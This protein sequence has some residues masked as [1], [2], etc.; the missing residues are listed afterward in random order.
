MYFRNVV[1]TV[2]LATL[3]SAAVAKQISTPY[4]TNE[5]YED[6]VDDEIFERDA[7]AKAARTAAWEQAHGGA[8]PSYHYGAE[9]DPAAWHVAR[10]AEAEPGWKIAHDGQPPAWLAHLKSKATQATDAVKNAIPTAKPFTKQGGGLKKHHGSHKLHGSHARDIEDEEDDQFENDPDDLFA[11]DLDDPIPDFGDQEV[12]TSLEGLLE[13]RDVSVEDEDEEE[14]EEEE[15]EPVNP[16][17]AGYDLDVLQRRSDGTADEIDYSLE[18][19]DIDEPTDEE[20]TPIVQARDLS[21]HE[22]EDYDNYLL[23]DEHRSLLEQIGVTKRDAE[24]DA[25]DEAEFDQELYARQEANGFFDEDEDHEGLEARAEIAD[26]VIEYDVD[27]NA[28]TD[29]LEA[30]DIDQKEIDIPADLD[31]S[32]EGLEDGPIFA[33]GVDEVDLEDDHGVDSNADAA[34][35]GVEVAE[36]LVAPVLGERDAST[37]ATASSRGFF[38]IPW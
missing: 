5:A 26:D 11:R 6:S 8:A 24:D 31:T 9:H 33:R 19:Y 23:S 4:T 13:A 35:D 25:H 7:E 1:C 29:D 30:R 34:Y 12:D 38:K 20:L 17:L 16:D 28:F 21:Q 37:T 32:L 10:D 22:D 27:E 2:A 18:G 36:E 14:E 3:A 15:E